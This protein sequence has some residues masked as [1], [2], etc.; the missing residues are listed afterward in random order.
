MAN[1]CL[2]TKLKGV[3]DNPNLSYIGYIMIHCYPVENPDQKTR[4]V[5]VITGVTEPEPSVAKIVNNEGNCYFTSPDGTANYGTEIQYKQSDAWN[6]SNSEFFVS[7]GRCDVIVGNKYTL[8][9]MYVLNQPSKIVDLSSLCYKSVSNENGSLLYIGLPEIGDFAEVLKTSKIDQLNVIDGLQH[10]SSLIFGYPELVTSLS[11]NSLRYISGNDFIPH[12]KHNISQLINVTNLTLSVCNI[13]LV[14][15]DIIPLTKVTSMVITRSNDDVLPFSGRSV[16][17]FVQGQR[18]AAIPRQTCDGL[19]WDYIAWTGISFNGTVFPK[20][21]S[22]YRAII[23]WTASTITVEF[24][25]ETITV[26][27]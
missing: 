18:A 4:R 16:E 5:A 22:A 14:L 11:L 21:P 10:I 20:I 13:N 19:Q 27:A 17:E 15:E 2:V 7:N 12:D 26:N 9:T 8:S 6:S 1:D 3:V 25:G 24:N 23:S